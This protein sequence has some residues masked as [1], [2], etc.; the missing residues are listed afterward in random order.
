VTDLGAAKVQREHHALPPRCYLHDAEC[1]RPRDAVCER[2]RDAVC[3][4]P[5]DAV[6][7]RPR[8]A[9]CEETEGGRMGGPRAHVGE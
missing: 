3:E 1:E 8:G 6:C 9:E 2:P 5:R 4:R 7:E